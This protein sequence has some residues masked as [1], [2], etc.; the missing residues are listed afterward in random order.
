MNEVFGN[1][2]LVERIGGGGLGEVFR[3]EDQDGSPV[4]LKRLNPEHRGNEDY[5]AIFAHESKVAGLLAHERLLTALATGEVEGWPF[6]VTRLATGGSLREILVA[7]GVLANERLA[8]TVREVGEALTAMHAAGFTH[9]D[10][11][12]DNVLYADNGANLTDFGSAT[13]IGQKQPR[14][15]GTFAYMSPEQVRGEVLDQRSDVF[16]LAT[17]L[18]Q[19]VSGDK[20][21]WR[22]AQHLTFMAVVDAVLPEV[23]EA[24]V[25]VKE[26]MQ[27]ALHPDPA[28]R[29][30]HAQAFCEAFVAGL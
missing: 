28:K 19:C 1:Y 10:L 18:W 24:L 14:P 26:L 27:S 15:Q 12:P 25:P 16:S 17:L 23:P 11:R 6:L 8:T 30:E 29:P 9:S 13:A 3:A 20:I 4:A 7:E 2:R 5:L 21:F 22:D